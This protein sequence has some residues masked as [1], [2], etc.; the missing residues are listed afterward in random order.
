MPQRITLPSSNGSAS[1]L[2]VRWPR[3]TWIAALAELTGYS[4]AQIVSWGARA[5]AAIPDRADKAV[6]CARRD[7]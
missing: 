6:S 7:A 1:A 3:P 4:E 5:R 2:R